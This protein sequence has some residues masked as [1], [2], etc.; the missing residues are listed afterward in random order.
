MAT[1]E[2]LLQY[3]SVIDE[4]KNVLNDTALYL[5]ENAETAFTEFKSAAYLCD[6]LRKEGFE[7]T[8][9][10][11]EEREQGTA[12]FRMLRYGDVG[13]LQAAGITPSFYAR[14]T[15]VYSDKSLRH[16]E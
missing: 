9:T 4:K 5:W 14:F 1:K 11:T 13:H 2:E 15:D 7:V 10:V 6:V 3:T 16:D 8:E 12:Q